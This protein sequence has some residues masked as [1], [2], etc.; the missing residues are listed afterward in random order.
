MY[1]LTLMPL[2]FIDVACV[3]E[4]PV[5]EHLHCVDPIASFVQ[6]HVRVPMFKGPARN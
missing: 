4:L 2:V 1:D 5:A 3:I 6:T